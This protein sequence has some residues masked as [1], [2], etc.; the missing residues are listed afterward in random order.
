MDDII[1]SAREIAEEK[2]AKLG[3]PTEEERRQWRYQPEGEKLAAEYLKKGT[4]SLASGFNQFPPD[5]R[6]YVSDGAVAVLVR[7]IQLP[8]TDTDKKRNKL[9]MDAIKEV[10]SDKVGVEN[11]FSQ[12][13]QLF[14][15]YAEQGERQKQTAYQQLKSQFEVKVRQALQQQMGGVAPGMKIDV[16]RQP[17]FQEEWRRLQAQ[18]ESQYLTL[19][20]EYRRELVT[21]R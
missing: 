21:R 12:I 9:A 19:L 1:K 16:E 4:G 5:A 2:V 11:V 13:R 17:Q 3:E 18:L 7:N 20:D 15:H 6:R 8:K 14:S 10:K